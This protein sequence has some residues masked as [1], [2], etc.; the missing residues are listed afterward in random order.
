[1]KTEV[2]SGNNFIPRLLKSIGQVREEHNLLWL[3]PECFT[4]AC[5]VEERQREKNEYCWNS[6]V[7][8][9]GILVKVKV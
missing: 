9:R 1:M 7:E 3:L 2:N 5:F 4:S 8:G 6:Y